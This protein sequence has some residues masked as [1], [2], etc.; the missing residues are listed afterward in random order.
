MGPLAA[1]SALRRVL[2]LDSRR[3]GSRARQ[4]CLREAERALAKLTPPCGEARPQTP[5]SGPDFLM[6]WLSTRTS[7]TWVE[8]AGGCGRVQRPPSSRVPEEGQQEGGR[9]GCRGGLSSGGGPSKDRFA[10]A[11]VTRPRHVSKCCKAPRRRHL[12]QPQALSSS[13][14]SDSPG[15]CCC[16]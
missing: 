13:S 9:E 12:L 7:C 14:G 15:T 1:H 16:L 4:G 10:A 5:F 11:S 6:P 2:Y 8:A 3:P